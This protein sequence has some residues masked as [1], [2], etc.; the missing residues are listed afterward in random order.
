M[1]DSKKSLET[2]L[3]K[4]QNTLALFMVR[5]QIMIM[6]RPAPAAYT[7]RCPDLLITQLQME[8]CC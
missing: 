8:L 5:L 3:P 6:A 4:L 1:E 2:M 7:M